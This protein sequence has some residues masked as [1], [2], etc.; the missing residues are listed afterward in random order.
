MPDY[1]DDVNGS[2]QDSLQHHEP[3]PISHH[4]SD[5]MIKQE[6]IKQE[7]SAHTHRQHPSATYGHAVQHHMHSVKA[8]PQQWRMA[9]AKR[10]SLSDHAS[11]EQVKSEPKQEHYVQP[12][13]HAY[14]QNGGEHW[15]LECDQQQRQAQQQQ[16]AHWQQQH[17][18]QQQPQQQQ[19]QQQQ[20]QEKQQQQE[21]WQQQQQQEQWQQ[22]E[23]QRQQGQWQQQQDDEKLAQQAES[24]MDK[25]KREH[26]R[27]R[28]QSAVTR[29][30]QVCV[31]M[32]VHRSCKASA[33]SCLSHHG[34]CFTCTPYSCTHKVQLRSF[35]CW[36]RS[37]APFVGAT[38]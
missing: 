32:N 25:L 30:H 26:L 3:Q 16:E 17:Q 6:V 37:A 2:T 10:A 9:D 36:G 15:R 8:E 35:M 13:A 28:Y 7:P 23:Q 22:Q 20:C 27:A 5:A 12:T 14:L 1:S 18:Q 4:Q 21:Q 31:C 29:K 24:E 33:V 38:W 19:Q 34:A 11:A